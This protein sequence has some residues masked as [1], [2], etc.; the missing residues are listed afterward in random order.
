MPVPV[1]GD[2]SSS[3][4]Q[5]RRIRPPA[6]APFNRQAAYSKLAANWTFSARNTKVGSWRN[7]D[8]QPDPR[9]GLLSGKRRGWLRSR[10]AAQTVVQSVTKTTGIGHLAPKVDR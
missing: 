7:Y 6:N 5:P 3:W 10:H 2:G 1:H 8:L 9:Q 4:Q